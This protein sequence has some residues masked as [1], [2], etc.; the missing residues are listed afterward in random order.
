[1]HSAVCSYTPPHVFSLSCVALCAEGEG[2]T[3]VVLCVCEPLNGVQG[4]LLASIMDIVGLRHGTTELLSP[5][6]HPDSLKIL[7]NSRDSHILQLLLPRAVTHAVSCESGTA[8]APAPASTTTTSTK[9]CNA[10]VP[11]VVLFI[12]A[13]PNYYNII[14]FYHI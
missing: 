12:Q 4:A 2:S 1:M 6:T 10:P 14:T 5:I 8:P 11:F 7:Q 9:V 3:C 13:A